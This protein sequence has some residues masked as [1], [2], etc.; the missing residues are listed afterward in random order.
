MSVNQ[1]ATTGQLTSVIAAAR[2]GDAAAQARLLERCRG[3]AR[4]V[5]RQHLP[6]DLL[7]K[8]DASDVAQH[9]L[10]D[11]WQGLRGFRGETTAEF[12]GWLRQIV[13]R[14]AVD[15][16]RFYRLADCRSVSREVRPASQGRGNRAPDDW[17]PADR[18]LLDDETPSEIAARGEEELL[19]ADAITE[20][21]DD[22]QQVLICRSL[23]R[24]PFA[25]VA[26]RMDRS[27]PAVQVL[28]ARAVDQLR[29]RLAEKGVSGAP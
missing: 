12:L 17:V 21:S 8:L 16:T 29:L 23:L 25:E 5:A 7:A 3:F 26:Q 11:A 19:L 20:L 14:N 4:V 27:R 22:H 24:L 6:R 10:L 9:S 18:P 1:P 15:A 2:D 28:W 13:S